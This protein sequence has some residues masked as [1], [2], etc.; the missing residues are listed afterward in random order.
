M[1]RIRATCPECGE[2]DLRPADI[3]LMIVGTNIDSVEEGSEYRFACPDCTQLVSKP[4]DQRIARLLATGGVAVCIRPAD[5]DTSGVETSLANM[6]MLRRHPEQPPLLLA[7]LT[8]DEL[9][10]FHLAL[11]ADDWRHELDAAGGT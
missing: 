11:E 4:A 3:D 1:T 9:I 8:P 2:V 6:V 5:V 7:P 10:D